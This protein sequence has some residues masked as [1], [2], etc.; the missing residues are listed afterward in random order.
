M[1]PF[2]AVLAKEAIA[3]LDLFHA[4]RRG[5]LRCRVV[6]AGRVVTWVHLESRSGPRGTIVH[7]V[8]LS[9]DR[10]FTALLD[11]GRRRAERAEVSVTGDGREVLN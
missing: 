7:C 4:L 9:R 10:R 8:E 6:V 1:T 11:G 5:A 3:A 2:L